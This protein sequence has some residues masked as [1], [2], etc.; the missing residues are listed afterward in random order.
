MSS[1]SSAA[2]P[3]DRYKRRAPQANSLIRLELLTAPFHH[4]SV[5]SC[6][7]SFANR[8][9]EYFS[10]DLLFIT[11]LRNTTL[12]LFYL[13]MQ[14]STFISSP[15][16]LTLLTLS[17]PFLQSVAAAKPSTLTTSTI[18]AA[19]KSTTSPALHTDSADSPSALS[20]S[21]DSGS[22]SSTTDSSASASS[23]SA[24]KPQW[25]MWF[26]RHLT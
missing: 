6:N 14:P 25:Y 10:S 9:L 19:T 13:T 15:F 20:G 17:A 3:Q 1:L 12:L 22:W 23:S 8:R 26:L 18:A 24:A 11:S 21:L 4:I 2:P 16:V 7:C 5:K